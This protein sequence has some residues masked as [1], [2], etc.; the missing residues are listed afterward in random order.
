MLACQLGRADFARL[1]I[2][3]GADV[4]AKDSLGAP[5][6]L[7][8]SL[9]FPP[10]SL[11]PSPYLLVVGRNAAHYGVYANQQADSGGLTGR[12]DVGDGSITGAIPTTHPSSVPRLNRRFITTHRPAPPLSLALAPALSSPHEHGPVG[13]GSNQGLQ[14]RRVQRIAGSRRRLRLRGLRGKLSSPP[15][16]LA[17]SPCCHAMAPYPTVLTI[18]ISSDLSPVSVFRQR[19]RAAS[20]LWSTR[21]TCCWAA[22]FLPF[23]S[24]RLPYSAWQQ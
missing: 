19:R 7:T 18:L 17:S 22:R 12:A 2:L 6:R 24:G 9:S 20:L 4:H 15:R 14:R 21:C 11:S 1:F 13:A 8:I 3:Q 5:V 10:L 16:S 23:R